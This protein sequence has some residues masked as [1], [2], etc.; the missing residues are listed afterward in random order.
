M[1]DLKF[2]RH[3]YCIFHFK[4]SI[5]KLIREHLRD[6]RIEQTQILKKRFKN[7]S[8]KFIDEEVEKIV[9]D[10][11][12]EI[13]YALEILYYLFKE[14]TYFKALS[15]FELIRANLV[16]FPEFLKEYLENNFMPIHKKFLYHLE[17]SHKDK[18]DR[19]NNQTE[20]FFRSTMPRG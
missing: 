17:F 9:K 12:R 14:R 1:R 6:L 11:K 19:T 5:N 3:Q 2:K 13:R 15:Y 10:E 16:N 4:L 20:G 18:L 8:Q 7:P